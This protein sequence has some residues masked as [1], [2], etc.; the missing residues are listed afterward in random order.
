MVAFLEENGFPMTIYIE[1]SDYN[2]PE[3]PFKGYESTI[4]DVDNNI[5]AQFRH[6]DLRARI[7]WANGF[8]CALRRERNIEIPLSIN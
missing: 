2:D 8:F 3:E 1:T 6:T 5:I 4:T 7:H